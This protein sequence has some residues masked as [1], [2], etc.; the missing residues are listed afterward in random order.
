NKRETS[1]DYSRDSKKVKIDNN[2]GTDKERSSDY[3]GS[4]VKAINSSITDLPP[5]KDHLKY[6]DRSKDSNSISKFTN[7]KHQNGTF[8]TVKSKEKDSARKRKSNEFDDAQIEE[9]SETGHRKGK[10]DIIGEK[11]KDHHSHPNGSRA[12]KSG[13][14]SSQ[15]KPS[16]NPDKFEKGYALNKESSG[17]PISIQDVKMKPDG[18]R[19]SKQDASKRVKPHLLPPSGK[20]QNK[21]SRPPQYSVK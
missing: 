20:G 9:T 15:D 13:K 17:K 1:Q 14:G 10:K 8:N 11:K 12:M 3:D 7:L 18:E 6:D 2:H 5:R 21:A 4:V 16:I 19:S